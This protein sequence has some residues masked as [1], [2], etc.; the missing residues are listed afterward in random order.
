MNEEL[1][2]AIDR[3]V[4][5]D[6][7]ARDR[8]HH[9]Q[10]ALAARHHARQHGMDAVHH[11]LG[12]DVDHLVPFVR[13]LTPDV[14]EAG[15]AGIAEHHVDRA[16]EGLGIANR[17]GDGGAVADVDIAGDGVR[18]AEPGHALQAARH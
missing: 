15:D 11:A 13:V 8:A 5:I 6:L 16:V 14:G 7:A 12:V 4:R 2:A 1:R 3:V 18:Q 10:R 17:G 9:H